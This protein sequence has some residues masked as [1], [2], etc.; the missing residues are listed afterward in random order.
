ML[1]ASAGGRNGPSTWAACMAC[2]SSCC[3]VPQRAAAMPSLTYTAC[4]PPPLQGLYENRSIFD[5]LDLAWTL[6]RLFPRE[7]ER[8]SGSRPPSCASHASQE[9]LNCPAWEL[10]WAGAAPEGRVHL[11][12][13][14]KQ[15]QV[16]AC[17]ACYE[18]KR[19]QRIHLPPLLPAHAVLRRITT[20]TLDEYYDRGALLSVACICRQA[21]YFGMN[22]APASSSCYAAFSTAHWRPAGAAA[23]FAESRD[24]GL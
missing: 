9:G 15:G 13:V 20:K 19:R 22:T 12:V 23:S 7:S 17:F 10:C 2:R 5:S 6:L 16:R 4:P 1:L 8:A 14:P 11:P 3:S 18:A 24:K 21:V